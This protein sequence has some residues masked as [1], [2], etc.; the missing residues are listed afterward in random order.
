[1][2]GKGRGD[3]EREWAGVNDS[4][5]PLVRHVRNFVSAE[6]STNHVIFTETLRRPTAQSSM[7]YGARDIPVCFAADDK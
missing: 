3:R 7:D 1:V 5:P 4:A 6:I 2:T